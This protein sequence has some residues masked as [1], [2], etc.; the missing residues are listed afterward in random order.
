MESLQDALFLINRGDY[1]IKL[2]L[3]C[4]YDCVNVA[5]ECRNFLQF[6]SNGVL[7]QYVGFSDVL[8]EALRIFTLILKP[9][10]AL[11]GMV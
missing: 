8:S 6:F 2:D 11:L 1:F 7:F 9:I 5:A 10:L 4:A 3:Q